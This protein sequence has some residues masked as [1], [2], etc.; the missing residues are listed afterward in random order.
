MENAIDT[1]LFDLGKVLLDW[2]PRYFYR[3]QFGGDDAAMETFLAE[4]ATHAWILQMDEGKPYGEAIAEQSKRFPQ[5][6]SM[7]A[8]WDE[9]WDTMLRGEIED[10]AHIVAE[11]ASRGRRLFALTNFS[12]ETWPRAT[13]RCPSLARFADVIVSGEH[14]IVKPDP[15][16]YKLAITRCRLEPAKTVFIDDLQINVDAARACGLHA[17]RFTG[18]EQLRG[19]LVALGVL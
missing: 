14:G 19:E 2:D 12:T 1:V 15:R 6:A 13:R 5:H 17:R 7:L 10:T 3:T 18:P 4:A 11:L 9:G 8:L 16:I